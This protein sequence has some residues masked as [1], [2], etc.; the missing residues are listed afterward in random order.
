M[1]SA[2]R[3][4]SKRAIPPG[5]HPHLDN[6]QRHPPTHRLPGPP[7][8]R[9]EPALPICSRGGGGH[10]AGVL[11]LEPRQLA[12][13][14]GECGASVFDRRR[15]MGGEQSAHSYQHRAA[16]RLRDKCLPLARWLRRK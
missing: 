13:D 2:C 4:C 6:L 11:R 9:A 12:F 8:T 14:S 1:A 16:A 3:S 15:F 5:I 10:L 7:P